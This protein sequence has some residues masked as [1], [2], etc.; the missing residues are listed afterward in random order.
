MNFRLIGSTVVLT[1][2]LIAC[3]SASGETQSAMKPMAEDAKS[4]VPVVIAANDATIP[5]GYTTNKDGLL[6]T[7]DKPGQYF[8]VMDGELREVYDDGFPMPKQRKKLGKAPEI[9]KDAKP[10]LEV[11]KSAPKGSLKN[12][13]KR[14]LSSMAPWGKKIFLGNSCNGCH[15]GTGGGGMCPPLSNSTWVYGKDD[16]TLFRLIT[17]GSD[18]YMKK[19][20]T[21][22]Q[23]RENVVGPMPPYGEIIKTDDEIWRIISF[24]RTI[25][26]GDPKDDPRNVH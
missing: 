5:A 22:R 26:R 15:G 3:V 24:I 16:D 9:R 4:Q 7:P 20:K 13:Y 21:T 14:E 11:V 6:V 17:L 1:A 8:K 10:P 12:P 19:Y 23:G 2:S 18:E 25:Y